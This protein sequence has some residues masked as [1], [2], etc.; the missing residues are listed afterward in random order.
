MEAQQQPFGP[1]GAQQD[2]V[3]QL[4]S[5]AQQIGLLAQ[6]MGS[7]SSVGGSIVALSVA[8]T[9][10]ASPQAIG[11]NNIST[12]AT[13]ILSTSS[14]RRGVMFHNPGTAAIYVY[15]TGMTT[16]PTTAILGGSMVIYPGGTLSLGPP[17][18]PNLS[19]GWLAF[20]VTGSSQ[21]LTVV[22]FF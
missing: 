18:F 10:T 11:F 20:S 1:T 8:T 19:S 17:S 6:A 9:T 14:L 22:E 7:G 5:I 16:A 2:S 3:Q 4:N 21:A 13:A 12:T 15:P